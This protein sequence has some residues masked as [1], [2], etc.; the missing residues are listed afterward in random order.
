M[1][2]SSNEFVD[3]IY[4][5]SNTIWQS[6]LLTPVFLF[7]SQKQIISVFQPEEPYMAHPEVAGNEVAGKSPP[8]HPFIDLAYTERTPSVHQSW[9]GMLLNSD[10]VIIPMYRPSD[11]ELSK[12]IAETAASVAVGIDGVLDETEFCS[13]LD[14]L[15]TK[16]ERTVLPKTLGFEK[17]RDRFVE[18]CV[19][20]I[21]MLH[22][23][24][25]E[26]GLQNE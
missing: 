21:I 14:I 11:D 4:S 18:L 22:K 8:T 16:S 17:T 6:C 3:K 24:T 1:C 9:Q 13:L 20:R 19:M 23:S 7:D 26:K 25:T 12:M 15:N 5:V 2:Q 10:M